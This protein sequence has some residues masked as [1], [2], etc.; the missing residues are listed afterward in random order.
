MS[1]VYEIA[2]QAVKPDQ[3]TSYPQ[4]RADFLRVLQ[5]QPGVERDWTFESFFTM[6]EPDQTRVLV[7]LTR[8]RSAADFAAASGKLMPTAEARAVFSK[9]D[10]RAFVQ[11]RTADGE[12]FH[13]EDELQG[14]DQVLEVAVRRPKAGVSEEQFQAARKGFFDR[15]AEQPGHLFDRELVDDDGNRVVLIGWRSSEDFQSALGALQA[16]PEMGA[17]FGILDVQAYQAARMS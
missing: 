10:M 5:E 14:P 11:V 6:P 17:F 15:I 3:T 9:V 7:G 2:I 1:H 13:L 4:A 16:C 8:W 12:P